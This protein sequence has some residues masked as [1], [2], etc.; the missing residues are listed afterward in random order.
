MLG[1]QGLRP[2]APGQ[3]RGRGAIFV[4]RLGQREPALRQ[5]RVVQLAR[6]RRRYSYRWW[7]FSRPTKLTRGVDR[8]AE[9]VLRVPIARAGDAAA[10]PRAFTSADPGVGGVVEAGGRACQSTT[11]ACG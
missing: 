6:D 9:T 11:A 7:H 5:R 1:G 10:L 8:L 3:A 2:P 4:E